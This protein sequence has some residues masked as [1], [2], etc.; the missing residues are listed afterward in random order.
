MRLLIHQ[1][2]PQV[3]QAFVTQANQ[4]RNTLDPYDEMVQQRHGESGVLQ[5]RL[6]PVRIRPSLGTPGS[7]VI[8]QPPATTEQQVNIKK[9]LKC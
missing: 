7:N 2:R 8:A 6:V 1:Q 9:I 5:Q 3:V 4:Q